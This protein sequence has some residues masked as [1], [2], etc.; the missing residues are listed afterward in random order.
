MTNLNDVNTA[1][2]PRSVVLVPRNAANVGRVHVHDD[3][4]I[5]RT[6]ERL[7]VQR[8]VIHVVVKVV[9]AK[10]VEDDWRGKRCALVVYQPS[11]RI[12]GCIW[13]R[14]D[15]AFV[16]VEH[17]DIHGIENDVVLV[18]LVLGMNQDTLSLS[19]GHAR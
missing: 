11:S 19:S 14:G 9:I 15:D 16:D 6:Q 17:V 5:Y 10:R 2:Q 7:L 13:R 18:G 1:K 4:T 12:S 8:N 3:L